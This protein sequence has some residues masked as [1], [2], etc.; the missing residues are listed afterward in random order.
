MARS[1]AT[2]GLV[3]LGVLGHPAAP[4]DADDVAAL[5]ERQVERDLRDLAG[6]EAH[7]E[8]LAFPGDGAQRR[9]R[10]GVADGVIDHVRAIGPGGVLEQRRQRLLAVAVEGPRG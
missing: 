9:L 1:S 7:D 8:I 10:I 5:Q 2:L 4:E 6:G 3:A